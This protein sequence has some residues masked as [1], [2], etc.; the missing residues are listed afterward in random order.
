MWRPKIGSEW[1]SRLRVE[2]Q[3]ARAPREESLG[4]GRLP[5]RPPREVLW[6][7]GEFEVVQMGRETRLE[8]SG[9]LV[10]A[11]TKDECIARAMAG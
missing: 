5:P 2:E 6:R 10:F 8:R 11:G 3:R 7:G 1:E 4:L 9:R